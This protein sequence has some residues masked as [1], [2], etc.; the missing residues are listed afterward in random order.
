MKLLSGF[1]GSL[2]TPWILVIVLVATA[3]VAS[4]SGYFSYKYAFNS[5]QV[6][7]NNIVNERQEERAA[8]NTK[9]AN[10]SINAWRAMESWKTRQ[11]MIF[12]TRQEI[13]TKWKTEYVGD[14][15]CGL[16]ESATKTLRQL[17]EVK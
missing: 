1:F 8:W 4:V 12:V 11:N 2:S 6:K 3:S 5:Q 15:N 10:A 16:S 9:L 7:I 13:I 17:W 14:P